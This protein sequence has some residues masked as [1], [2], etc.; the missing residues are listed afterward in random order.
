MHFF[1]RPA[2]PLSPLA[3]LKAS[4]IRV[5]TALRDGENV[6]DL[7]PRDILR[8]AVFVL[9]SATPLARA[10]VDNLVPFAALGFGICGLPRKDASPATCLYSILPNFRAEIRIPTKHRL[11]T[12]LVGWIAKQDAVADKSA[13]TLDI[14]SPHLPGAEP[15]SLVYLPS[16]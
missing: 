2:P 3:A 10:L 5:A 1:S 9:R 13:L 8:N 16:F 12:Q 15:N 4:L 14:T 7:T 6:V 11:H